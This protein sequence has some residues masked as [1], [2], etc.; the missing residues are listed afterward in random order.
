M[1]LYADY[2]THTSYSHAKGT[3]EENI[4]SAIKANLKEIGIAEH[5]PQTLFVGV[6]NKKFENLYDEII[7]LRDKY[8]EIKIL[9]N[10]EA[11]LLDYEGNIDLPPFVENKVDMLLLGF[12][13]NIVPSSKSFPMVT[14][15]LL[16]RN[17]GLRKER[18]RWYNTQGLIKAMKKYDISL[19]THPGHKVDVDTKQLAKACAETNTALEI[20]CKHGMKIK[21]F[22]DIAKSEGV[23]F[24]VS[25]DAHHPNE[26]GEFSKGISI[27]KKLNIPKSMIVNSER[28]T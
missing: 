1:N 4:Q 22:V 24:I 17:L 5:G 28:S 19:I 12:H 7:S 13:P 26:V 16:S 3:V 18:T 9:F 15:N 2:H 8:P 20:N 6:S 27:I 10:I 23:K 14:N 11:N 25:S 21:D